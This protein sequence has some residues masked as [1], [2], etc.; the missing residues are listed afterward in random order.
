M[1]SL[2][3]NDVAC[4]NAHSAVAEALLGPLEIEVLETM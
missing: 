2:I 1:T 3:I 4:T